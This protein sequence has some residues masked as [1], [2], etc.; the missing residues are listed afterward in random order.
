MEQRN[1]EFLSI[2]VV[3]SCTVLKHMDEAVHLK[4]EKAECQRYS[5]QYAV[6]RPTTSIDVQKTVRPN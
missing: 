6:P 4:S 3:A 1:E 2:L 5:E